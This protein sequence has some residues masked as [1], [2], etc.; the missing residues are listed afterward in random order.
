ME[1]ILIIDSLNT[2][3]RVWASIPVISQTG[4]HIGGVIGFL[5]SIGLNIREY[6][7][8]KVL[9]VFDGTGGSHRRR[10]LFPEYKGNRTNKHT[11]R[12]EFFATAE[13]EKLSQRNQL[14]RIIEYL[15]H[16]PVNVC[17]LDNIEAD[18]VIAY[19]TS[20]ICGDKTDT[21]VRIVSTD[22]DFL[23][24]VNDRVEVYSPVK[25]KLYTPAEIAEEYNLH[26]TNYL[27]YRC[28]SGDDSDNINGVSG[29]GLKTLI[30][31]FPDLINPNYTLENLQ[32]YA[33]VQLET[34]KKPKK[35]YNTI[36]DSW[37]I[38]E[39]NYKL[40]QLHDT[41]ISGISKIEILKRLNPETKPKL[42][43]FKIL[44]MMHEDGLYNQ[45]KNPESWIRNTF[46]YLNL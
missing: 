23:Q 17:V 39:R 26:N 43:Y 24:L 36:L 14:I 18:D 25:K 29:V 28:L 37:D 32:E 35:I 15:N 20:N 30:K 31:S 6:Q 4:E 22:R 12:R 33:K 21:H 5:R 16:L 45:F 3:L 19:V 2:F 34:T 40:M 9:I 10:K 44:Q 8:T 7:P 41:D 27:I 38:I 42:N 1:R 46:N 11:L 13:D